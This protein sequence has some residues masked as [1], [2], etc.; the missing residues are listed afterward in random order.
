MRDIQKLNRLL[1][2]LGTR[3][4]IAYLKLPPH[5]AVGLRLKDGSEHLEYEED[6]GKLYAYTSVIAGSRCRR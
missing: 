5:G 2:E 3:Y 6:Q 4:S 1:A